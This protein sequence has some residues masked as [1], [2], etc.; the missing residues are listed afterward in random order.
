[1][2]EED[3]DD[4]ASVDVGCSEAEPDGFISSTSL[5]ASIIG[6]KV[7]SNFLTVTTASVAPSIIASFTLLVVS[8]TQLRSEKAVLNKPP[9]RLRLS[10]VGESPDRLR[11]RFAV[12]QGSTPSGG[13]GNLAN[14]STALG[15]ILS[16]SSVTAVT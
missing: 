14:M 2:Q 11:R 4:S 9:K 5:S 6:F 13:F 12:P 7:S 15:S 3:E 8:T 1:V 16:S 10:S